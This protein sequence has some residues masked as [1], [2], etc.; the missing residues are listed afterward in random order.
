MHL[1][2]KFKPQNNK[3]QKYEIKETFLLKYYYFNVLLNH[4]IT[5]LKHKI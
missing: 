3:Q 5:K 4:T 1:Q 2:N